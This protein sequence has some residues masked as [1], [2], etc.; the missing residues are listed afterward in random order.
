M[1]FEP[2]VIT[3]IT[4]VFR[5][6]VE[7]CETQSRQPKDIPSYFAKFFSHLVRNSESARSPLDRVS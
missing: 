5:A 2:G 7:A 6:V 4:D 1:K 3:E